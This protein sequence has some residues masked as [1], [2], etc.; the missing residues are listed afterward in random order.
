MGHMLSHKSVLIG[1]NCINQQWVL[2]FLINF[3]LLKIWRPLKEKDMRSRNIKSLFLHWNSKQRHGCSL[4]IVNEF[5][6]SSSSSLL[7]LSPD[8]AA[9]CQLPFIIT[10]AQ[11]LFLKWS[12][13]KNEISGG[14]ISLSKFQNKRKLYPKDPGIQEN[15]KNAYTSWEVK[16]ITIYIICK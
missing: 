3:Y 12:S 4:E 8:T 10:P 16:T 15:W 7:L 9:Q 13:R 5:F 2:K 11:S 14:F 1:L 6:H